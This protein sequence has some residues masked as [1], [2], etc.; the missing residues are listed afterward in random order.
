MK[1]VL[2]WL[3]IVGAPLGVFSG[4]YESS[5]QKLNQSIEQAALCCWPETITSATIDKGFIAQ[6]SYLYWQAKEGGLEYIQRVDLATN[7]PP[8][9][10]LA[11]TQPFEPDS[12]WTSG[13]RVALGYIFSARSQ[14]DLSLNW[15]SFHSEASN[16][17]QA[18][19]PTLST[20]MLRPTW[21]PFL[22]GT[23][24]SFGSV[25][26]NLKYDI[27]NLALGREFFL[28]K[29]LSFHPQVALIGGWIDQ[30]YRA[31]YQGF[32]ASS[33][34]LSPI[35]DTGYKADWDYH[36]MGLR[37]GTDA[38][39]H[40]T[41]QFALVANGFFSILYGK[42]SL[43]ETFQGAFFPQPSFLIHETIHFNDQY[44]RLRPALETEIGVSWGRF[45]DNDKRRV[46]LGAYYGFTYWF[47]QNAMVNE[48]VIL[49]SNFN[50]FVTLL[51]TQGDLQL[52]G[53]R[54]E[55]QLDF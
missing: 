32:S 48:F 7:S 47:E 50:S 38:S 12:K 54:I 24:A 46:S 6:G 53:L 36:A 55:A 29:W 17:L 45:F 27:V 19:D 49:D 2:K 11:D 30:S 9:V 15:T 41:R 18:D 22:M 25:H 51:P 31:A 1:S 14:W 4:E 20:Q 23:G 34:A 3:W 43:H 44:Y 39:W 42:Y 26:W 10:V 21:L 28:G 13:F 16:V 52:Q 40:I 8:G 35:G 37:M 5:S 33:G